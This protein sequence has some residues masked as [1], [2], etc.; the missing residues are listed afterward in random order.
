ML[1]SLRWCP[2]CEAFRVCVRMI[3][4]EWDGVIGEL[5]ETLGWAADLEL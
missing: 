5:L 4:D 2:V 3:D 1:T